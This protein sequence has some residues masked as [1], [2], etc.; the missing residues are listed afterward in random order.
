MKRVAIIAATVIALAAL[1][2]AILWQ[3]V[4]F[5]EAGRMTEAR[6][7]LCGGLLMAASDVLLAIGG[8]IPRDRHG[9]LNRRA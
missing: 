1:S 3:S 4:L 5:L 8:I 9:S 2:A 6:C 7:L